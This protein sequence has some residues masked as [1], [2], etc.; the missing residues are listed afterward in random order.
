MKKGV[1]ELE[2]QRNYGGHAQKLSKNMVEKCEELHS[3]WLDGKF[4]SVEKSPEPVR[5]MRSLSIRV[6]VSKDWSIEKLQR[7][8]TQLPGAYLQSWNAKGIYF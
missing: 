8:N 4:E 1:R 6:T 3:D 2:K 5:T 7:A